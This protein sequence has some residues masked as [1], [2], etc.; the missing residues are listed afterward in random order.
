MWSEA[1]D[2]SRDCRRIVRATEN[3]AH[4]GSLA[5]LEVISLGASRSDRVTDTRRIADY[6]SHHRIVRFMVVRNRSCYE[7]CPNTTAMRPV[8]DSLLQFRK[9]V[10]IGSGGG[11]YREHIT[12]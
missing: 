6:S 11:K 7:A 4:S 9:P 1:E 5:G 3:C 10:G 2:R 8:S 12:C